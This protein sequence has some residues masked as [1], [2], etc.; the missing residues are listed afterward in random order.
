VFEHERLAVAR[1]AADDGMAQLGEVDLPGGLADPALAPCGPCGMDGLAGEGI[2][3]AR[4]V[5]GE[6][7]QFRRGLA[8]QVGLDDVEVSSEEVVVVFERAR[9]GAQGVEVAAQLVVDFLADDAPAFGRPVWWSG[10][11][12]KAR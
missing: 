4:G 12:A 2:R 10:A 5:V 1:G 6:G 11:A 7:D 3:A 9:S 8:D